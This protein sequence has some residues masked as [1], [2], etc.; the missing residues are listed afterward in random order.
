[1]KLANF[2]GPL[3]A[4]FFWHPGFQ[5]ISKVTQAALDALLVNGL[6]PEISRSIKRQKIGWEAMALTKLMTMD[7]HFQRTLEQGG[8]QKSTRLIAL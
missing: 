1:M 8:K 7:E 5:K 6:S 4:L 2:K 3:E